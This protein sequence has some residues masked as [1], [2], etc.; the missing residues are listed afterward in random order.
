MDLNTP[1]ISKIIDNWIDEDI[2][3]GDLTRPSITE[4]NGNAYW[5]AKE[6]G[7]FCGVEIIKE[8]F[9]KIDLNI[10]SKFNISDGNQFFKDQKLLE[11]YGP[12]KSLLAS[13]RIGLNIAMHLSGISTYTKNLVN[14]LEGTNIKLADTRKT[15]PGLRIFEKY[16]F[17]CGGGV[18]HRMGLYD[19]AMIKENHIAWTDN[20]NNAVKKIRLNSPFTTHIIIEAENIEQAKEAVLAGA[21]SVLLDELSPE[22]IQKNVQELRDLSMNSLKKEVNKNLIIEVSGINPKE[23][24][25]YLIKGIDLI[26]TSSSITKS[27]WIDLSMRYIN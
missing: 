10:S 2:G 18:N 22:I 26:S 8:I 19:A 14:K 6:G 1:I 23:I 3:R 7:I 21:D 20:L 4:E 24:S 16:A 17:K 12:S 15:T 11:I 25:K 9:K 13:E 5:I 27:N